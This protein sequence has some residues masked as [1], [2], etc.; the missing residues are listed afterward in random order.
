M[1]VVTDVAKDPCVPNPRG[2]YS[3]PPRNIGER[4][5]CSCLPGMRGSPPNCQ[6]EC[7]FNQ[8]CPTDKACNNQKCVD[9]CPGLCGI[10]A[11]CRVRNHIP[12][13]VAKKGT[14]GIHFFNVKLQQVFE[15]YIF[16]F[17]ILAT[18]RTVEFIEPC[19]P[20]PSGINAECSE[21]NQAASCRCIGDN[22]ENPLNVNQNVQSTQNALDTQHVKT[23]NEKTHVMVFV[24]LMPHVLSSIT[25]H[26]VSATQDLQGMPLMHARESQHVS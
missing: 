7:N 11:Y 23:K 1:L 13:C 24:G 9:P 20:S 2:Q 17:F 18:P 6:P 25:R 8:D 15:K 3:Y 10:N 22:I 14:Q 21:R 16:M 26:C 19:N 12:I 5:D 4:C